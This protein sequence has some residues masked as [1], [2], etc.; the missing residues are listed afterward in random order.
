MISMRHE[1]YQELTMLLCNKKIHVNWAK[2]LSL[3]IIIIGK[4][5][6]GQKAKLVAITFWKNYICVS[7]LVR[8]VPFYV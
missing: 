7:C 4:S 2:S 5:M 6:H 8:M 1:Y 3:S